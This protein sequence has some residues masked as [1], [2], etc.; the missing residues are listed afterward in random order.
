MSDRESLLKLLKEWGI[1]EELGFR[2]KLANAILKWHRNHIY[3]FTRERKK[4]EIVARKKLIWI[5]LMGR[6]NV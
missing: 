2:Y 4:N 1:S 3:K 6:T 5:G